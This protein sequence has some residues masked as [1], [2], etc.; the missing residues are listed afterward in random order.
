VI[1][2]FLFILLTQSAISSNIPPTP[3]DEVC[4]CL[5]QAVICRVLTNIPGDLA[6]EYSKNIC[7][8]NPKACRGTVSDVKTGVYGAFHFC[9]APTRLSWHLSYVRRQSGSSSCG[10]A[11]IGQYVQTKGS[12]MTPFCA[13]LM[14]QIGSEGDKPFDAFAFVSSSPDISPNATSKSGGDISGSPGSQSTKPPSLSL[15][16]GAIA[17]I[18][19]GAIVLISVLVGAYILRKRRRRHVTEIEKVE[20]DGTGDEAFHTNERHEIDGF[21]RPSGSAPPGLGI[22]NNNGPRPGTHEMD[23]QAST[24]VIGK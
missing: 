4:E 18:V 2:A 19:V 13:N 21:F 14:K 17:G 1:P 11:S 12:E 24:F 7:Q 3:K 6:E 9:D 20:F 10:D 16:A 22:A 23:G 15:S 5:P 8:S